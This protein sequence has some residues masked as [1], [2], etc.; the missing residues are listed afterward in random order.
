[1]GICFLFLW[2]I[3]FGFSE[4]KKKTVNFKFSVDVHFAPIGLMYVF[5]QDLKRS[6]VH[7]FF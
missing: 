4:L 5:K 6:C 1:M 7:V 3:C 2:N